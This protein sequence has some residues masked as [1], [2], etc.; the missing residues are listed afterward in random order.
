MGFQLH[1]ARRTYQHPW[2]AL[3][4]LPGTAQRIR[5]GKTFSL[6]A[7]RLKW[8]TRPLVEVES[9]FDHGEVATT[10]NR[11]TKVVLDAEGVAG[12]YGD[13]D[14][15]ALPDLLPGPET[16]WWWWIAFI[17]GIR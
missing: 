13:A 4:L 2:R 16:W 5:L 1:V 6:V 10:P 3:S 7:Y 9:A 8:Q 15:V 17:G 11:T 14:V 12:G